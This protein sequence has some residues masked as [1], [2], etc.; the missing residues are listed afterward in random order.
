MIVALQGC[1]SARALDPRTAFQ[2]D[3]NEGILVLHVDSQFRVKRLASTAGILAEGLDAGEHIRFFVAP[4]GRYSWTEL[5]RT[6]DSGGYYRYRFRSD[7]NEFTVEAGKIN[8]PG[9]L[10]L[11][12]D[13]RR[14]WIYVAFLN[15]SSAILT[16]LEQQH[17]ELLDRYPIHYSGPGRDDFFQHYLAVRRDLAEGS[18]TDG[19]LR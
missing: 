3:E 8:Y 5:R 16:R 14:T 18:S 12:R 2:L 9:L 1:V 7:R 17:P 15:R 13:Q 11:S 4:S 10:K 6:S 19:P